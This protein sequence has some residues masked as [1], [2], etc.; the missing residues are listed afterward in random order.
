M[1]Q[2][3]SFLDEESWQMD[4]QRDGD[5][6]EDMLITSLRNLSFYFSKIKGFVILIR[7]IARTYRKGHAIVGW[8]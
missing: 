6:Q 8:Y 7:I 4:P 5:H 2:L 3:R 1:Y